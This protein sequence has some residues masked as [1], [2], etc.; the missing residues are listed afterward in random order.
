MAAAAVGASSWVPPGMFAPLPTPSTVFLSQVGKLRP[1]ALNAQTR[2][3][4][5]LGVDPRQLGLQLQPLCCLRFPNVSNLKG[6]PQ[7]VAAYRGNGLGARPLLQSGLLLAA[8]GT[9]FPPSMENIAGVR[10]LHSQ[11]LEGGLYNQIM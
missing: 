6:D 10:H 11:V 9:D 2:I 1:C 3:L 8:A 5:V 4:V 7:K